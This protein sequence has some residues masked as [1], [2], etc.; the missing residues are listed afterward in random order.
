MWQVDEGKEVRLTLGDLI[1]VEG[2]EFYLY[3]VKLA[4]RSQQKP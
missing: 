2:N 3:G 1:D 4:M